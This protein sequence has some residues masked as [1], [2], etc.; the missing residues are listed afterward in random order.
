[1]TKIGAK[2]EQLKTVF[3]SRIRNLI[4]DIL[5][6]QNATKDIKALSKEVANELLYEVSVR[7]N[8]K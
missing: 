3:T 2:K 1:M 8:L 6:N 7:T 4:V 5:V